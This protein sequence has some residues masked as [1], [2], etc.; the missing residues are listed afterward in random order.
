MQIWHTK[1]KSK[2]TEHFCWE[3]T[4]VGPPFAVV[5]CLCKV[6][7]GFLLLLAYFIAL[8]LSFIEYKVIFWYP[9]HK[10]HAL[11]FNRRQR[12]REKD[13]LLSFRSLNASP[14]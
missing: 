5:V 1:L 8:K 10:I 13:D 11:D 14:T 7:N 3:V 6:S 9:G 12:I 4:A 2:A